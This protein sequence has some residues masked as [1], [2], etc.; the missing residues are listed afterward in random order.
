MSPLGIMYRLVATCHQ[1]APN[2]KYSLLLKI[3]YQ[4]FTFV[5]EGTRTDGVGAEE[6]VDSGDEEDSPDLPV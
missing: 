1:F 6:T 2:F 3:V 5:E 4:T